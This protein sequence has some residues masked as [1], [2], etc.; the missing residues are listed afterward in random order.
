MA[1]ESLKR[2]GVI[3]LKDVDYWFTRRL[4]HAYPVYSLGYEEHLQTVLDWTDT[5][6]NLITL[7]RQ[8]LF[9][10]NNFHHSVMMAKAAAEHLLSGKPKA[11]GWNQARKAFDNFKV[12]D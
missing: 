3:P 4:R 11:E 7:G 10:H 2:F 1:K 8:G 5:I 9:A 6:E 12:I